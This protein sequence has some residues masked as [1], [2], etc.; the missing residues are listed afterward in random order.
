MG[1]SVGVAV[2]RARAGR[3]AATRWAGTGADTGSGRLRWKQAPSAPSVPSRHRSF[4]YVED[5]QGNLSQ[6]EP[7]DWAKPRPHG[8]GPMDYAVHK[9]WRELQTRASS[10]YATDRSRRVD[11]ASMSGS[12]HTPGPGAYN[13]T[14]GREM[15][16]NLSHGDS[17]VVV[18][19]PAGAV[20]DRS[21]QLDQRSSMFR[22]ATRKGEALISKASRAVPGPGSHY[23]PR[24]MGALRVR[25]PQPP[26]MQ[27]FGSTS[28][29]PPLG[30]KSITPGPIYELPS[31][32]RM[33]GAL[34]RTD[35]VVETARRHYSR[36]Q[37]PSGTSAARRQAAASAASQN[38]MG[39]ATRSRRFCD[40][41]AKEA[42]GKPGAGTY[43]VGDSFRP[44]LP[45]ANARVVGSMTTGQR[46]DLT[47]GASVI[48]GRDGE[49][50]PMPGPGQ[51]VPGGFASIHSEIDSSRP[52]STFSS[53]V[54]RPGP[55][56][57]RLGRIDDTPERELAAR[58]KD[59]RSTVGPGSYDVDAPW[60]ASLSFSRRAHDGRGVVGAGGPRFG[61]EA[62]ASVPDTIGPGSY[63][64]AATVA[65]G[66]LAA[67]PVGRDP[68]QPERVTRPSI[69][70]G[71]RFGH[72]QYTSLSPGPG[73]YT[74][75]LPWSTRSYNVTVAE[76]ELLR[77]S[78]GL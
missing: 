24:T 52:T 67:S 70:K 8:P 78:K 25:R 46:S 69:S 37:A 38:R 44:R 1:G 76:Q 64:V 30:G 31:S 47:A 68:G 72:G 43:E 33:R 6:S 4:G 13:A 29:R 73:A 12:R 19:G 11:L 18:G 23:N 63:T 41:D 48:I 61:V 36:L 17:G 15:G 77:A 7:P 22:S 16:A 39:F 42:A 26:E 21:G 74:T 20:F 65:R 32:L 51:Y 34:S 66:G 59:Y 75:H 28:V 3:K 56:D 55:G 50:A 54:R 9:D 71:P 27:H 49:A 62:K 5:E 45:P 53:A 10:S 58:G 60:Q 57:F 14:V 40:A 2:Q 35:G